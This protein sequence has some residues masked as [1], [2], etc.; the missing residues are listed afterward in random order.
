MTDFFQPRAEPA[1]SIYEAFQK[2]AAMR[3][4]R[5][6]EVWIAAER[7]AVLQEAARQAAKLGLRA[8]TEQEVMRA[9]ISA[10]GHVDYGSKWALRVAEAMRQ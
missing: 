5:E 10:C 2:E 7:G 8:P 9:E 1:R 3:R 4:G 6:P